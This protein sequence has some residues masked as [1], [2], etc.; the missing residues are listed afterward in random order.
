MQVNLHLAPI[1][2][3][4][5]NWLEREKHKNAIYS[6]KSRTQGVKYTVEQKHINWQLLDM[7]ISL[8]TMDAKFPKSRFKSIQQ[9]LQT[10]NVHIEIL[11]VTKM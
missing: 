9:L 11:R 10:N 4:G 5:G 6:T 1:N 7:F 2:K 3:V 8:L